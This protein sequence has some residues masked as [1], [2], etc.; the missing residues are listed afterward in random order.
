MSPP[1][2]T[3]CGPF[4][5]PKPGELDIF[6][7]MTVKTIM[8]GKTVVYQVLV[9]IFDNENDSELELARRVISFERATLQAC[10]I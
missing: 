2:L 5:R 10:D 7:M 6:N 3:E 9:M 4:L 1:K 8:I